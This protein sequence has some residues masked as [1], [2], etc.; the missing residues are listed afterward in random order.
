MSFSL[1]SY[2]SELKDGIAPTSV[3]KMLITNGS[4]DSILIMLTRGEAFYD[5]RYSWY[6]NFYHV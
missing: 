3:L 2:I 6:V 1:D 5:E 4:A